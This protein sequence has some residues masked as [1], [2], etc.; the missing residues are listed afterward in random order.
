MNNQGY[1]LD[2]TDRK[3]IGLLAGD[4][5]LSY[6]RIGSA[7]NLTR[8]SI[9]TRVKRM[10]YTGVIQEY[11]ADINFALLDYSIYYIITKRR[12]R[13]V[14]VALRIVLLEEEKELSNILIV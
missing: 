6:A 9:K 2:S 7:L 10:T 14:A 8:N 5:R 3:I 1:T 13:V 4:S 12:R 11:I